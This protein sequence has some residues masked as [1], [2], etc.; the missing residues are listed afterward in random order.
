MEF[1]SPVK[2]IKI[3]GT[4]STQ[5]YNTLL[6]EHTDR[7]LIPSEHFLK[8]P[9]VD[10]LDRVIQCLEDYYEKEWSEISRWDIFGL[11]APG[12]NITDA[13]GDSYKLSDLI[14]RVKKLKE[15]NS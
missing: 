1:D 5:A 4:K 15:E 9:P 13:H 14:Y 11:E 2:Y 7:D 12:V 8:I 6:W 10:D 3:T